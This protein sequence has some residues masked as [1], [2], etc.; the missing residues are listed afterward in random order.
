MFM[1]DNNLRPRNITHG[2]N[3]V[4]VGHINAASPD[5]VFKKMQGETMT[6]AMKKMVVMT[7]KVSSN[8]NA[9]PHTSMSVGDV[10]FDMGKKKY[11]Q[12]DMVGWKPV[13]T[14]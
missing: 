12:C 8:E 6:T 3:Y 14:R 9:T 13:K 7:Q 11:F 5:E 2:K 1:V 10:L 4:M